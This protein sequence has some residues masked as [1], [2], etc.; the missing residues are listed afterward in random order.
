MIIHGMTPPITSYSAYVVRREY[1]SSQSVDCR[2][3]SGRHRTRGKNRPSGQCF[4]GQAFI[5]FRQ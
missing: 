2:T 1:G 3:V 4:L 5:R